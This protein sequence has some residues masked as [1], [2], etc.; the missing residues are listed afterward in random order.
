M[1]APESGGYL[2][3]PP[4]SEVPAGPEAIVPEST[5]REG[6][7]HPAVDDALSALDDAANLPPAEQVPVYE[8]THKALQQTLST[9]DQ[10]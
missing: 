10:S 5:P 9:I 8:A 4:E 7:G 3:E 2:G 1:S 6:T